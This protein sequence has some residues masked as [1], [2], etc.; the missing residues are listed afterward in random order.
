MNDLQ[1]IRRAIEEP[2]ETAL[3][4]L[5]PPIP[6]FTDNRFYDENDATSE[7]CLVRVSFGLMSDP[8]IGV[9]GD[10]EFIR[11]SAVI[12]VYTPKGN[13][14][15]RGQQA[16]EVIWRTLMPLNR[17]LPAAGDLVVRTGSFSGPTFTP[18]QGRPHFFT[19][20]SVPIRAKV[21]ADNSSLFPEPFAYGIVT[22]QEKRLVVVPAAART[23]KRR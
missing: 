11:G 20:L 19:R 18:L 2:V 16:A 21:A 7:F 15:G 6:V 8:T 5:I 22:D 12:E 10:I 3:A 4:A 13:G 9:C 14:P 1:A 17:A 23:R